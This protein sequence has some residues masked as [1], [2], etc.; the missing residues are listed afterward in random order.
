MKKKDL[1]DLGNKAIQNKL[2]THGSFWTGRL[3]DN[4]F[5]L[6]G[7][8]DPNDSLADTVFDLASTTKALMTSTLALREAWARG[9]NATDTLGVIFS[10]A[11]FSGIDAARSLILSDVLRHEAGLPA[12][13]NFYVTCGDERRG[14]GAILN[15]AVLA[16]KKDHS[17]VYS[18]LGMILLG[19]LLESQRNETLSEIF[20]QLVHEDLSL[21]PENLKIGPSWHHNPSYCI[22]TGFCY[23]RERVLKGEVHDENAA[24]LGGFTGHT[25]LFAS[26]EALVIYLRALWSSRIGRRVIQENAVWAAKHPHSDSAL[27]WRTGRDQS[28]NT[29]GEGRGIGHMGFVG[30]A[31]WLDPLSQSFAVLLTNRVALARTSTM[32]AMREFRR[33]AFG[34]MY[35]HIKVVAP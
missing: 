25:G 28:S 35:S 2:F 5:D 31:F 22:D 14:P 4:R 30:T 32:P 1:L 9:H 11:D 20:K 18:D 12:W 23:V 34:M 19:R 7:V 16:R 29:F 27:G 21:N 13:R 17:N 3:D 15:E 8:F 26:T 33:A 10:R 6:S 24:V